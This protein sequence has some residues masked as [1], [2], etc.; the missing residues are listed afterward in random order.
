METES[1]IHPSRPLHNARDNS[2]KYTKKNIS[3]EAEKG[4]HQSGS[5]WVDWDNPEDSIKMKDDMKLA[6]GIDP[7][8]TCT[9]ERNAP[10]KNSFSWE[11]KLGLK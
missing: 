3:M 1:G 5:L 11:A 7:A 6:K 2:K 8:K 10:T 9:S 4:N